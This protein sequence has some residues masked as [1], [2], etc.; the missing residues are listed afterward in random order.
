MKTED[1]KTEKKLKKTEKNLKKTSTWQWEIYPLKIEVQ[2]KKS[3]HQGTLREI[4]IGKTNAN[5]QT[6][7]LSDSNYW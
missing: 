7:Y 5:Q 1:G 2:L 4:K 3:W 6:T